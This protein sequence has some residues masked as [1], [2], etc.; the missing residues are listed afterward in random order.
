MLR[1]EARVPAHRFRQIVS[2]VCFSAGVC[3]SAIIIFIVFAL[4]Y[5][6]YTKPPACR[7]NPQPPPSILPNSSYLMEIDRVAAHNYLPTEQDILRVR[8][9]T[10]GIIEYPFDLEEIR[11]RY[12]C[13]FL[14]TLY[15]YISTIYLFVNH[16]WIKACISVFCMRFLHES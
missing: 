13:A 4:P 12:I 7:T 16:F 1:P 15:K 8:V 10:T 3:F 14:H 9:P 2:W 5:L 11:F 6:L